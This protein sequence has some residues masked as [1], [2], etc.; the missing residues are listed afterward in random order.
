MGSVVFLYFLKALKGPG[1][2]KPQEGTTISDK[3]LAEHRTAV[4]HLPEGLKYRDLGLGRSNNR[5]EH[6]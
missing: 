2:F 6:L 5:L 4:K 3:L 1:S